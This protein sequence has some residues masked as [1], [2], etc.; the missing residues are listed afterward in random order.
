MNSSIGSSMSS[1]ASKDSINSFTQGR[2]N[3]IGNG[4]GNNVNSNN[5]N[6][7]NAKGNTYNKNPLQNP[8]LSHLSLLQFARKHPSPAPWNDPPLISSISLS[9]KY[10][11]CGS[12]LGSI[13][14][15]RFTGERVFHFSETDEDILRPRSVVTEEG[16]VVVVGAENFEYINSKGKR[17]GDGD[18]E[19]ERERAQ[20]RRSGSLGTGI[21]GLAANN[22]R[23]S[24]NIGSDSDGEGIDSDTDNRA[25][26]R[27]PVPGV[28]G[29]PVPGIRGFSP[30][31]NSTNNTNNATNQN[32]QNAEYRYSARSQSL[33]SARS[34]VST[35]PSQLRE[36]ETRDLP[37]AVRSSGQSRT[38]YQLAAIDPS[39]RSPYREDE[40]ERACFFSAPDSTKF[41]QLL[42]LLVSECVVGCMIAG[43]GEGQ[44]GGGGFFSGVNITGGGNQNLST[45]MN[46]HL[47]NRSSI[48]QIQNKSKRSY[49]DGA[50]RTV[51]LLASLPGQCPPVQKYVNSDVNHNHSINYGPPPPDCR[52]LSPD[53]SPPSQFR[54]RSS[55]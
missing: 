32:V 28:R 39:N 29:E 18:R 6:S 2:N 50:I 47:H 19:R 53:C 45:L 17:V 8:L 16:Y 36:I 1:H 37:V 7:N 25:P 5:A 41:S 38:Y 23:K 11:V 52:S 35:T 48:N 42:D 27:S 3:G 15:D 40:I 26:S 9:E 31:G 20:R 21:H 43:P 51:P 13:F 34:L 14:F 30:K 4:A 46:L 12:R 24:R 54:G 55:Q 44:N 10:V 33:A 22:A 49:V